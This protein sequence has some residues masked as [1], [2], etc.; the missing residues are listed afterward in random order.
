MIALLAPFYLRY[1]K[2]EPYPSVLLPSGGYNMRKLHNNTAII[3]SSNLY[4]LNYNGNWQR[5]D[6]FKLL[7]PIPSHYFKFMF[8]KDKAIYDRNRSSG[9][10]ILEL[11]AW[12]KSKLEGQQM[13]GSR[14]KMVSYK[15]MYDLENGKL[16][17]STVIDEKVI[18]VPY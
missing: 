1:K 8:Y 5:I 10:A 11:G 2:K 4:G 15:K 12:L 3:E 14:I 17:D 6:E 16:L 9:P 13:S 7:Y 18:T